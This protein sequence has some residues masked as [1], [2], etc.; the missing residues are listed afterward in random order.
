MPQE[1][2]SPEVVQDDQTVPVVETSET[3]AAPEPAE[4][5]E[6]EQT[7][8]PAEGTEGETATEEEAP[9]ESGFTRKAAKLTARAKEAEAEAAYWRKLATQQKAEEPAAK[10][11]AKPKMAD[12]DS[13]EAYGE[14]IAEYKADEIVNRA[15][16]KREQERAI[17]TTTQGYNARVQEFKKT[18]PDFDEVFE[19][20][21]EGPVLPP[22]VVQGILEADEGPAIAYH[23]AKNPSEVTRLMSLTPYKRML[24]LGKIGAKTAASPAAKVEATKKIS[25]APGAPKVPNASATATKS[26]A[27]MSD[28]EWYHHRNKQ[29]K[30]RR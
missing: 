12:F 3:P 21:G 18:T 11:A 7:S 29:D 1:N 28:I 2:V 6:A 27:T 14:A 19:E 23:L 24:E 8:E 15:L 25:S 5:T 10:P 30:R 16:A 17:Q 13:V 22:E 26:E 20:L 9:R 4:E